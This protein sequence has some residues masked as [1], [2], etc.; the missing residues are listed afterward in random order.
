MN[1]PVRKLAPTLIGASSATLDGELQLSFLDRSSTSSH[2]T[3]LILVYEAV[4]GEPPEDPAELI[5]T[6]MTRALVPYYPV[7]GRIFPSA[8]DGEL[9]VTCSSGGAGGVWFV[10]AA[11]GCSLKDANYLEPPLLISKEQLLPESSFREEERVT[12][13]F[14]MQ[15]TRFRCGGV[16]VGI[17]FNHIL[18]DGV[19]AGQFT[20]AVADMARG[21]PVPAVE[22][23]WHRESLDG[24]QNYPRKL[25]SSLKPLPGLEDDVAIDIPQSTVNQIKQQCMT[26]NGREC[27][28]FQVAAA[29]LWR[30]RARAIGGIGESRL[31]HHL[32]FVADIRRLI[33]KELP[34]GGEGYYGNCIYHMRVSAPQD[35]VAEA[36]ITE[37]VELIGEAKAGVEAKVWRFINGDG[38]EDP[39]KLPVEYGAVYVTDWRGLGFSEVD[40]GWGKP[41]SVVPL[42]DFSCFSLCNLLK[43]PPPRDGVRLFGNLV[44]KEHADAFLHE[45]KAFSTS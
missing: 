22:P 27:T 23:I 31:Q 6:G 29:V 4:A 36:P 10:E 42:R 19:G 14:M 15:I 2:F 38:E 37:I 41:R 43:P 20:R 3:D 16:S 39:G 11:A 34:A 35:I 21:L 32:V 7:A 1:I 13:T 33:L 9:V 8:A 12:N 30:C 45:V 17:S 44:L 26:E 25:V 28:T 24:K 40:F 18:F 5:R